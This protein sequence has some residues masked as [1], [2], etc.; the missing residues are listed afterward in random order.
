MLRARLTL[1]CT[2]EHLR[3]SYMTLLLD[4]LGLSH[5][6]CA[7]HDHCQWL[8][9]SFEPVNRLTY[10][11]LYC[12]GCSFFLRCLQYNIQAFVFSSSIQLRTTPNIIA[13]TCDVG[14]WG[15][16]HLFLSLIPFF[17]TRHVHY[18]S[19]LCWISSETRAGIRHRDNIQWRII[20]VC[21]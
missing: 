6:G 10:R 8:F 17:E 5:A 7:V 19:S 14:A 11:N 18:A 12:F 3:R 2:T 13:S 4:N 21:S 20:Q 16:K 15:V 1:F 9:E